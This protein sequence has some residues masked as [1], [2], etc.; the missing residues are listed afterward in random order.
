MMR[1]KTI[2]YFFILQIDF[3]KQWQV[4]R[5]LNTNKYCVKNDI[6]KASMK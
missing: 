2:S 1:N 3:C 4:L 5:E 6:K